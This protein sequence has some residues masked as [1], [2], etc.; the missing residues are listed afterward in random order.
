MVAPPAREGGG[1]DRGAGGGRPRVLAVP[2]SPC[3]HV[4]V[5]PRPR[6]LAVPTSPC[7]RVPASSRP[8]VLVRAVPV[9]SPASRP[10]ADRTAPAPA[11]APAA[12]PRPPRSGPAPVP[13]RSRP[14][15]PR[16]VPCPRQ[17][18][19]GRRVLPLGWRLE[20]GRLPGAVLVLCRPA[21]GAP[22]SGRAGRV[23]RRGQCWG[24][25]SPAAPSRK[26]CKPSG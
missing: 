26:P 24:R 1:A 11:P 19:A 22:G 3:P 4:P 7:P 17:R 13:S 14:G 21:A 5:S 16:P 18:A 10:P 25:G 6:V 23:G 15:S 20:P 12:P 8:R 9:L 2:A